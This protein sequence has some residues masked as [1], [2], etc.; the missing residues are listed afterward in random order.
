MEEL[1]FTWPV[2]P[3][4]KACL[5]VQHSLII[6][7]HSFKNSLKKKSLLMVKEEGLNVL[8]YRHL[9]VHSVLRFDNMGFM[10]YCRSSLI[11]N[12]LHF[13]DHFLCISNEDFSVILSAGYRYTSR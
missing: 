13:S 9:I 2:L 4:V 10:E 1:F 3:T 5:H 6:Q 11:K 8:E 12:R 7:E